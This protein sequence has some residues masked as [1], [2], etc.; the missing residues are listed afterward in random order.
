MIRF[1]TKININFKY[2]K[3]IVTY[4]CIK[5]IFYYST[6]KSKSAWDGIKF[7]VPDITKR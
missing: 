6:R 4:L 3:Y 2:K 7:T 1:T 5:L